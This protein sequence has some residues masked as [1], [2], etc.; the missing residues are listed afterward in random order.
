[1]NFQPSAEVFVPEKPW[2]HAS[3]ESASRVA[4]YASH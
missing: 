2:R 3:A 1:M 4:A